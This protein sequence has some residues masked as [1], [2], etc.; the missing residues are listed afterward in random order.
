MPLGWK[1]GIEY[2]F[3]DKF[4]ESFALFTLICRK[5]FERNIS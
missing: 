4:K 1:P 5:L 2:F 3:E